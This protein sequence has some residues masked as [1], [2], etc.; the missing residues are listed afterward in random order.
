VGGSVG[1]GEYARA[2]RLNPDAAS[3]AVRLKS[4]GTSVVVRLKPDATS[5]LVRL[6]ADV[7][8][9]NGIVKRSYPAV[10]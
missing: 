7:E 2:V 10:V 8:Y 4:D 9:A 6:P 3:V 5:V 1:K